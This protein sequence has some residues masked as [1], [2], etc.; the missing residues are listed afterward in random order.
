MTTAIET[1]ARPIIF[2]AAMIRAVLAGQ[3]TMTRRVIKPQPEWKTRQW[4]S[5][6]VTKAWEAGFVD[7]KCPYGRPDDR[8]WVRE[9]FCYLW[10]DDDQPVEP[11][12]YIYRASPDAW[13]EG[14]EA[15]RWVPSIFMPRRASRIM[16]EVVDIRVQRLQEISEEDAK[17]EGA[18]HRI[19]GDGDLAGA[20]AHV[21]GPVSYVAHFKGLWDRLNAKRGFGWESNPWCWVISFRKL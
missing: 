11:Y 9:T 13:P 7:V 3:K 8:L 1:R 10:N 12:R 16:L 6:T 20:F 14:F 15:R 18:A 5:S 17:A 19:I 21:E 4:E 2:S